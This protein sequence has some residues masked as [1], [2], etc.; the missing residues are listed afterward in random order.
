MLE[1][2]INTND[3]NLDVNIESQDETLETNIE[4]NTTLGTYNYKELKNKP[5]INGFELIGNKTTEEL[6][7]VG[8]SMTEIELSTD[9]GNPTNI[10]DYINAS[11][12]YVA[13]NKGVIGYNGEPITVLGKGQF[14]KVLNLKDLYSII[15]EELPDEDNLI[16]LDIPMMDGINKIFFMSGNGEIL[17]ANEINSLNINDYVDIDTSNLLTKNMINSSYGIKLY[18][19]ILAV[20]QAS[21]AEIDSGNDVYKSI[22]PNN[23]DYAVKT[24]GNKYFTDKTSFANLSDNVSTLNEDLTTLKTEIEA[25]LDSVVSV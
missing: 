9:I 3:D 6:G 15:G 8:T 5:S 18:N 25:I 2:E 17:E 14:F 16:R 4:I 19:N 22:T 20:Q 1:M 11:G 24:K 12:T 23:I 10:F 21:N 13:K 7:I